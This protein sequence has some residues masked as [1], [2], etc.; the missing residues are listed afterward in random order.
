MQQYLHVV[1]LIVP[2]TLDLSQRVTCESVACAFQPG[3]RDHSIRNC[4]GTWSAHAN[5]TGNPHRTSRRRDRNTA[6]CSRITHRGRTR[7]CDSALTRHTSDKPQR[8]PR[9]RVAAFAVCL[10][11]V[12]D[13]GIPIAPTKALTSPME[14][15]PRNPATHLA[16]TLTK[17]ASS[18]G[19]Q[20]YGLSSIDRPPHTK[21]PVQTS[22]RTP[23]HW[24]EPTNSPRPLLLAENLFFIDGWQ[25]FDFSP[26]RITRPEKFIPGEEH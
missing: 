13:M 24:R 21:A 22:A 20:S 2:C 11:S 15:P 26:A 25:L 10:A 8:P 4:S 16:A 19:C 12:A 7:R 18:H 14:R 9:S 1:H 23:A 17:P 6:L 5:R 3:P